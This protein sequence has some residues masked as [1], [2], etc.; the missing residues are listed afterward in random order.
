MSDQRGAVRI[1]AFVCQLSCTRGVGLGWQAPQPIADLVPTAFPKC[2]T[3]AFAQHLRGGIPLIY[4]TGFAVA[5]VAPTLRDGL[6]VRTVISYNR[7][8]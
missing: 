5:V 2:G 3:F 6:T 8:Y 1:C 7:L 4:G